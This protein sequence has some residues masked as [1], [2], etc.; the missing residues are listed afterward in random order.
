[1][2]SGRG[3]SVVFLRIIIVVTRPS[4]LK[5][6]KNGFLEDDLGEILKR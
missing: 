3:D 5:K 6:I 4:Y 2:V 1:M